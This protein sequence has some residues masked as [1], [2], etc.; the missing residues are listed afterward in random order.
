LGLVNLIDVFCGLLL[1]SQKDGSEIVFTRGTGKTFITANVSL[2]LQPLAV[3][4]IVNRD[5]SKING[6]IFWVVNEGIVVVPALLPPILVLLLVHVNWVLLTL[7]VNWNVVVA[8]PAQMVCTGPGEIDTTTGKGFT[9]ILCVADEVELL[10][11]APVAVITTVPLKAGLYVRVP[12]TVLN[13]P[14]AG[15]FD[16]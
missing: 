8:L 15:L 16:E 13:D 4:V 3:G 14:A 9:V 7:E 1:L 10:H 2:P 11:P 5:E 6:V 12:L